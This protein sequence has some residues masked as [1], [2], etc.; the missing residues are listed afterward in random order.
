MTRRIDLSNTQ[1]M[2]P[3]GVLP[4]VKNPNARIFLDMDGVL[5]DF[6]GG[7]EICF[8]TDLSKYMSYDLHT[9][10]GLTL[11]EFWGR[12]SDLGPVFW[13]QLPYLDHAMKVYKLCIT[14]ADTWF[15]T[16]PSQDRKAY[17][18][19]VL[20]LHRVLGL[21]LPY[22]VDRILVTKHKSL[23]ANPNSMLI[24]DLEH[25][26]LNFVEAGGLGFLFPAPWNDKANLDPMIQLEA[27]LKYNCIAV[28]K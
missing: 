20:W 3:L 28:I 14:Y 17:E 2:N 9:P 7:V 10:L 15:L 22:A 23:L 13:E 18:G 24:D 1:N 26:V 4:D 25:N 19:K 21:S 5:A 8:E 12:I 11:S 27:F 6:K 16:S